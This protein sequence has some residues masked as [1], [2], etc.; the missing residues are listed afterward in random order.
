MLGE[1]RNGHVLAPRGGITGAT[2]E[3]LKV[4]DERGEFAQLASAFHVA[5]L[6]GAKRGRQRIQT[7]FVLQIRGEKAELAESQVRPH[8]GRGQGR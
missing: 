7:V 8:V 6:F 3:H 1:D 4:G 5:P 2:Q